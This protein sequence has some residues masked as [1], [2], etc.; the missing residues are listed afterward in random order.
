MSVT[1]ELDLPEGLIRQARQMGVGFLVD[2]KPF[3]VKPAANLKETSRQIL[4]S[5]GA[6]VYKTV[7]LP[8]SSTG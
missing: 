3:T 6:T 7:A 5:G 1:I 2:G 4:L 8:L